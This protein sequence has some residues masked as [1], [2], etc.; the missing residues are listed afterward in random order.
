MKVLVTVVF[1]NSH[2]EAYVEVLE[3]KGSDTNLKAL[4]RGVLNECQARIGAIKHQ[5]VTVLP[6]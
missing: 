2:E 3:P 6:D 5:T 4:V 1:E